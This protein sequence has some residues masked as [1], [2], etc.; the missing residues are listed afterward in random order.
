MI[1]E[2]CHHQKSNNRL[3]GKRNM[4]EIQASPL[5]LQ[6]SYTLDAHESYHGGLPGVDLRGEKIK[7]H[8]VMQQ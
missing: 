3:E 7:T 5:S 2:A 4:Q 6:G 1:G 8:E